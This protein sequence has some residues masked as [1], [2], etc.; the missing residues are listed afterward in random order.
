MKPTRSKTGFKNPYPSIGK[1][2]L[3]EA[4]LKT[5]VLKF[6]EYFEVVF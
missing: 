2:K 4:A 5:G 1:S 6:C 3:F